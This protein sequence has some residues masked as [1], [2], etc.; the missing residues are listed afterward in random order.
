MS[1]KWID[2]LII[3]WPSGIEL[4]NGKRL[5]ALLEDLVAEGKVI[6][7]GVSDIDTHQFQLLYETVKIKP[8]VIQIN[9]EHCCVVPPELAAF[10]KEKNLQLLTHNDPQD[11]L[12]TE[13]LKTVLPSAVAVNWT[14]RYQTLLRCRGIIHNKGYIISAM[15]I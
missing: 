2:L 3:V 10:A 14:A 15:V 4:E 1:T 9:L 5:W 11:I 12:S 6:S 13:V 7:L 8:E